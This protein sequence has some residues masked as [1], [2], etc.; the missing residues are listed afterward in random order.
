MQTVTNFSFK[1][2]PGLPQSSNNHSYSKEGYTL[3]WPNP[4]THPHHFNRIAESAFSAFQRRHLERLAHNADSSSAVLVAPIIQGGQF[5]IREEESVFKLLFRHLSGRP[6]MDLTSGYFSLYAPYQELVLKALNLRC[7]IVVASPKVGTICLY[8]MSLIK[9]FSQAN[10]F[11]G[12]K[13]ISGRIP[14]GYTLYEKRFM[15]AV[16]EAG[17]LSAEGI[18][19]TEWEKPGWTYHAKGVFFFLTTYALIS[20][21]FRR[22]GISKSIKPSDPNPFWIN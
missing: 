19:L 8:I 13:G 15:K 5:N 16:E 10:G 7:R 4:D 3:H 9:L 20:N 11:F 21:I 6:F 2:L 18:S 14:E 12:S 17:R 1:L 22:M